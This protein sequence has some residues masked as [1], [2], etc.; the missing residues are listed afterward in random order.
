M[1]RFLFQEDLF[2]HVPDGHK[3][4]G[5]ET[6]DVSEIGDEPLFNYSASSGFS[7]WV[8]DMLRPTD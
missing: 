3:W 8:G 1:R 6:M 5:R 2:L 7:E 4:E